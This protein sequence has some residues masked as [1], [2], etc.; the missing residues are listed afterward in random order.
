MSHSPAPPSLSGAV[1][2]V[3]IGTRGSALAQLQAQQV[4]N[5]LQAVRPELTCELV[6]VSTQG[7]R[8][9]QTPLSV[10]GGQGIFVR[11]LQRALQDGEIDCAVHSAKDM[12]A[13][14]PEHSVLAAI[15]DRIDPRD[16]LVS[17]HAGGL[18]ALPAGARVG[19]SSPRRKAQLQVAR[20]DLHMVE[21]RGNIDTRISKVL[22]DPE[23]RYDAAILAAAGIERMGWSARISE[24]LDVATFTPAPGQG[25]LGVE[26]RASDSALRLLLAEV[27]D[28][29]ATA[30]VETER[31]FL[32]ALGGGCR[33]PLAATA[34][35]ERDRL[36]LWAMFSNEDMTRVAFAQDEADLEDAAD[37][38]ESLARDLQRQVSV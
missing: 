11:E 10:I 31:A 17:R 19:A 30:E 2:T 20:P 29:R 5:A 1:R 7:D 13:Q 37:L 23:Q 6:I 14:F 35:V 8:D 4:V 24:W 26:C 27:A 38:A 21:L 25:A 33:S 32:R 22:D 9:K 28:P 12:P 15:L 16:V 3:R 36:H 18:A 34:R